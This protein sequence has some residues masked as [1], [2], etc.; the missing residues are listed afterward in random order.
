MANENVSQASRYSVVQNVTESESEVEN[1][2]GQ[3]QAT[4][5]SSTKSPADTRSSWHLRGSNEMARTEIVQVDKVVTFQPGQDEAG[6]AA[7]ES[8]IGPHKRDWSSAL[9]LV[10]EACEAIRISEER[11]ADL[12]RE[13]QHAA[14]QAREELRA[15]QSQI[16]AAE[17]RAQNAEARAQKAEARAVEAE[18]WLARLHDAISVGF[19]RSSAPSDI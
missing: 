10:Q 1:A 15:L 3:D 18:G 7:A 9:D 13:N 16:H 17:R 11:V 12:E 5:Q 2:S 14:M 6:S 4:D 19:A 8:F